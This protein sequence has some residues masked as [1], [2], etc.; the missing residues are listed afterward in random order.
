MDGWKIGDHG[1]VVVGCGGGGGGTKPV[2]D[3]STN[4]VFAMLG[5]DDIIDVAE[6]VG[7]SLFVIYRNVAE[8]SSELK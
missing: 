1:G 6:N 5:A 2:P 4:A 3:V 8:E 7:R